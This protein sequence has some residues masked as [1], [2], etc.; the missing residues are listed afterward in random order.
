[1]LKRSA[2]LLIDWHGHFIAS[3][4][5]CSGAKT[6][7]EV[8]RATLT[9]KILSYGTL[10]CLLMTVIRFRGGGGLDVW[11]S[12]FGAFSFFSLLTILFLF[13]RYS[14]VADLSIAL[15]LALIMLMAFSDGGLLSRVLTWLPALPLMASFIG[16][17]VRAMSAC[18]LGV[19]GLH[20]RSGHRVGMRPQK[21]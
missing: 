17:R 12:G 21:R 18:I 9:I 11:V 1:M 4:I 16:V 3:M 19:M 15:V 5:A 14:A 7:E 20:L 6:S 13:G 10:V 8:R 2:G